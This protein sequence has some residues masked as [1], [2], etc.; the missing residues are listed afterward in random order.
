MNPGTSGGEGPVDRGV[1]DEILAE[2]ATAGD[3]QAR[4]RGSAA[5]CEQQDGDEALRQSRR[6]VAS[7]LVS[8]G[9]Q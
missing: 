9:P 7:L 5:R 8:G 1:Q 6:G 4:D 2:G 3:Q